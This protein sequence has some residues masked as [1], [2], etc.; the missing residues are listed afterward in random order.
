[1]IQEVVAGSPQPS[2]N[3]ELPTNT[4][5]STNSKKTPVE[6]GVRRI[7]A[8]KP[9][10]PLSAFNLFYRYKRQK[11]LEAIANGKADKEH[12]AGLVEATPGLE[13]DPRATE[14]GYCTQ[15]EIQGLRRGKIRIDLKDNLLPR[16][17][18]ARTHRTNQNAMNGSMS[19]VE[20]GKL[21]NASWKKCDVFSKNVFNELS[22]E[23]REHYRK[24]LI[25]YNAAI[26]CVLINEEDARATTYT[27]NTKLSKSK[28]NGDAI[29]KSSLP[30]RKRKPMYDIDT[31]T[32]S[33]GTPP[34]PYPTMTMPTPSPPRSPPHAVSRDHSAPHEMEHRG[35]YDHSNNADLRCSLARDVQELE[36]QLATER[37][38]G[39]V[40][41]LEGILDMQQT[42]EGQLRSRLQTLSHGRVSIPPPPPPPVASRLS[43]S[44]QQDGRWSIASSSMMHPS[45]G[46]EA[47]RAE[48]Q[49]AAMFSRMTVHPQHPAPMHHPMY[50]APVQ[51][52]KYFY[53]P[54][55]PQEAPISFPH[56]T[57][58]HAP[59]SDNAPYKRLR[60]Y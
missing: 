29:K 28:E 43:P 20:L 56:Q 52:P 30:L 7:K 39:R 24:R 51:H 1:M 27:E 49:R 18:R 8:T 38:A 35:G 14:E 58:H 2:H 45:M 19:F 15:P 50:P 17:T 25:E 41:E 32:V 31:T 46:A 11:I 6:G 42:F 59:S 4:S 10:R 54:A 34:Y 47:E 9:K 60:H 12:I 26:K 37:L 16:D 33:P 44:M 57:M 55:C 53:P 48:H 5:M 40:R 23:G 36:G 3:I 22:E 21:M 13:N